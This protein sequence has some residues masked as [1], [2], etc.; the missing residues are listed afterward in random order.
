MVPGWWDPDTP[1]INELMFQR[2][3]ALIPYIPTNYHLSP[4]PDGS[5][6]WEW[7]E[8]R[9]NNIWVVIEVYETCYRLTREGFY[10]K[11]SLSKYF[12]SF[13]TLEKHLNDLKLFAKRVAQMKNVYKTQ[14][15]FV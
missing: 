2:T 7:E 9:K 11:K 1:A 5:F 4:C 6:Q 8:K 10:P 12:H 13:E 14:E 15:D 3:E